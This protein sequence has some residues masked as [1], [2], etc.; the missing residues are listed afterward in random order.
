MLYIFK[1]SAAG[2]LIM[3][4]PNGD[5]VLEIIGKDRGSKG[6]ILPEQMPAAVAA[7]ESAMVQDEPPAGVSAGTSTGTS[8]NPTK[9][10]GDAWKQSD[11]VSLRQRVTPFIE[12]LKRCHAAKKEIVWGV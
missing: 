5:R 10:S 6:I 4:E 8:A 9:K 1:S 3:L 7:L 12:M 11:A 2:N